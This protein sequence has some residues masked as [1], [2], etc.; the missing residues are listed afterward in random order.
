MNI[1]SMFNSGSSRKQLKVDEREYEDLRS[2]IAAISRSQA[3]IEFGVDG[4][5]I[6]A[7]Q[8]FL[9]AMGYTLDE[10]IGQHHGIFVDSEYRSS[11]EY[12]L[13]WDR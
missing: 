3:V 6:N 2:Q 13:I 10:I 11:Q 12:R 1:I 7:N 8:N 4:K 5:I 9:S